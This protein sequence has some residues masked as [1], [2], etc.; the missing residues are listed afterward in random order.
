MAI[1]A[2]APQVHVADFEGPLD[3]LL[4]LVRAGKMDVFD[5]PIVAL[6]DQY[7]VH[8]HSME[9]LDLSVAGEFIVM[10]ATL[11]EIKSRM[12]LPITPKDE[13]EDG[14]NA[15]IEDPRAELV[16]RLLEYSQYQ[17]IA[18]SLG[19]QEGERRKL[20]FREP[21]PYSPEFSLA[22]KFGEMSAD[23]LLSALQRILADVGAGERQITSVRR[24][25][26][27][28][29]MTM[30]LVLGQARQAGGDGVDLAALL[31][32]PPW[33]RIEIVLLFL[34]LLE[35]L[36]QCLITV[37]QE[38]FCGEIRI[39]AVLEPLTPTESEEPQ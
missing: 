17:N 28:L 18:E 38:D 8:L 9:T 26:V 10:A 19:Q 31:P 4:H 37:W 35:L 21:T 24:Q 6:C 22:P 13:P 12:L 23:A 36:K 30:R 15:E 20:F 5:L 32:E 39:Y 7:L 3:L 11:L 1:T 33:E 27:T 2:D 16:R 14:E 34:S 29:R 25:K